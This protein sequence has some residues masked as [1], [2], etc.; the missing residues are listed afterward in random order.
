M[1]VTDLPEGTTRCPVCRGR[2]SNFDKEMLTLD[3]CVSCAGVGFVVESFD[4]ELE[5]FLEA[6]RKGGS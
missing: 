5:R 1:A 4:E 6:T 3:P 2:G